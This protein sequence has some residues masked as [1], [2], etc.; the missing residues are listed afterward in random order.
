MY[1]KL[2]L[3]NV[4]CASSSSGSSSST[5]RTSPRPTYPTTPGSSYCQCICCYG[6]N[7]TPYRVGYV[8]YYHQICTTTSCRYSCAQ[9]YPG[10]C[11]AP[12]YGINQAY[13]GA[14]S[15]KLFHFN[16]FILIIGSFFAFTYSYIK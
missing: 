15:L 4:E 10:T 9:T 11:G 8:L 3:I 16:Y 6:T 12:V 14:S 5:K 7:C 2:L 13:C 1:F